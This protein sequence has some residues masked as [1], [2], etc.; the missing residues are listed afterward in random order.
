MKKVFVTLMI[1]GTAYIGFLSAV[2][3]KG[4]AANPHPVRTHAPICCVAP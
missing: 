2:Q 1:L 4:F 3:E